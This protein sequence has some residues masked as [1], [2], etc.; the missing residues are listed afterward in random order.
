MS[1]KAGLELSSLNLQDGSRSE[2]S[3]CGQWIGGQVEWWGAL[4]PL[5]VLPKVVS[6]GVPAVVMDSGAAMERRSP[7]EKDKVRSE[8]EPNPLV[9][10]NCN[11]GLNL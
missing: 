3:Q 6:Q 8:G 7:G 2:R 5:R 10:E 4:Q 9:S 1:L 11:S